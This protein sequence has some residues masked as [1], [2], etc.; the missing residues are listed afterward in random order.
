MACSLSG[1]GLGGRTAQWQ[2]LIDGTERQETDEGIRLTLPADRAGAVAALAAAERRFCPSFGFR[3]H[4]DGPVLHLQARAP[5]E[6]AAL[7][8][9][10]FGSAV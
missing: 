7:L 8:A 5:S 9:E 6:G 1:D 10:L 3:L 2:R 4:L